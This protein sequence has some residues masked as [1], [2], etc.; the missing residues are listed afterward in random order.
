MNYPLLDTEPTAE[1]VAKALH[2]YFDR[3]GPPP[4]MVK[5]VQVEINGKMITIELFDLR[6]TT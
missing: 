6:E 1:Q 3:N 5:N 4:L 2:D